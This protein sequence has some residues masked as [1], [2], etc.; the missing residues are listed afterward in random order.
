MKRSMNGCELTVHS[1]RLATRAAE[2]GDGL[3]SGVTAPS[4][5]HT[6]EHPSLLSLDRLENM[7]RRS[8]SE[9]TSSETPS[10][11][12]GTL[13]LATASTGLKT[14]SRSLAATVDPPRDASKHHWFGGHC[15]VHGVRL[16]GGKADWYRN[17]WIRSANMVES[18]CEDLAGRTLGGANNTHVISHAG[19]T[20][21]LVE[22]G[23]PPVELDYGLNAAGANNFFGTLPDMAFTAH[24]KIDP[25]TGEDDGYL[26]PFVYDGG[27]NKSELLILDAQ[28]FSRQ[29]NGRVL[30]PARVPYGFHGSLNP[31]GWIG[32]SV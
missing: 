9:T 4:L 25:D 24:P 29:P 23:S 3:K 8:S 11:A 7:K 13:A 14:A 22:V 30:L 19:R 16:D 5:A 31:D 20:W 12:T 18:F 32:P 10:A 21:A 27:R 15:M 6:P 26:L 1:D 17:R 2:T 28:D